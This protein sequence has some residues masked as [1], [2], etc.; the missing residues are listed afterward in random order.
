[1]CTHKGGTHGRQSC[2]VSERLSLTIF[3]QD[4]QQTHHYSSL[5]SHTLLP[6]TPYKKY[7]LYIYIFYMC[8]NIYRC[9]YTDQELLKLKLVQL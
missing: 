3:L 2:V 6:P 7:I 9:A 8:I 1:M 5:P 4:E